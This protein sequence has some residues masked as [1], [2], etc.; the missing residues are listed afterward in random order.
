MS[1]R[2][3]SV[4][5][6]HIV[7]STRRRVHRLSP[8]DDAWIQDAVRREAHKLGATL[9]A[10]GNASNHVHALTTLPPT[11]S[12]ARLV[13]QMKGG[14][15]YAW[16]AMLQGTKK[17]TAHLRWQDGYW[18]ESCAPNAIAPLV[19]YIEQQRQRHYPRSPWES[20]LYDDPTRE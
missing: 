14:S 20:W 9:L 13:Q 16:N 10:V 19:E 8:E 1:Q 3:R 2:S 6:V 11:V 15:S 18:A 4:L 17:V 12:L 7:W 5:L